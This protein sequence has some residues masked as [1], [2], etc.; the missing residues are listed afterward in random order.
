MASKYRIEKAKT[1]AIQNGKRYLKTNYQMHCITIN[2]SQPKTHNL[3]FALSDANNTC[4]RGDSDT[5]NN[6]SDNFRE[7]IE[8]IYKIQSIIK[9]NE[10]LDDVYDGNIAMKDI[11]EY[12]KHFLRDTQQSKAKSYAFHKL[13]TILPFACVTLVKKSLL[14]NIVKA[15]R[16]ILEKKVRLYI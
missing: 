15:R 9:Y 1:E 7:L 4:L 13:I 11:I 6:S 16:N 14:S 12:I 3:L 10:N 2:Y 8:A 5:S